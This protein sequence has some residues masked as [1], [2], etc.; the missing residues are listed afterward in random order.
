MKIPFAIITLIS[1]TSA[2]LNAELAYF[3]DSPRTIRDFNTDGSFFGVFATLPSGTSLGGI[4]FGADGTLYASDF[5]HDLVLKFA[6]DGTPSTFATLPPNSKPIGLAFDSSGNLFAAD[7]G[8]STISKIAP[9]G[10]VTPFASLP[11]NAGVVQLAFD[12]SQNLFATLQN[13]GNIAKISASGGVSNFTPNGSIPSAEGLTFDSH[14]NLFT[15]S[16]SKNVIYKIIPDGSI[17]T[18]FNLNA[19]SFAEGLA[20]DAAGN[21]LVARDPYV[22][23]IA[24]SGQF[25]TEYYGGATNPE[26]LAISIPEPTSGALVAGVVLG[27]C[28]MRRGTRERRSPGAG[29]SRF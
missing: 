7:F 1:A 17:S 13:T 28:G 20:I 16:Y 5:A 24:P 26:W 9:G 25:L 21:I 29:G 18:F 12:T 2:S 22:D 14:G 11:A 19:N 10:A 23:I 3:T 6:P 8:T 4:T 27:W 15:V